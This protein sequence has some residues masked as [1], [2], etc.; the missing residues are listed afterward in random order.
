MSREQRFFERKE[1]EDKAENKG[2]LILKAPEEIMRD[3]SYGF[4]G[5]DRLGSLRKDGR[6][7]LGPRGIFLHNIRALFY[8][9]GGNHAHRKKTV[10]MLTKMARYKTLMLIGNELHDAGYKLV[11]PFSID[12]KHIQ[13]LV[14]DWE[15]RGHLASTMTNKFTILRTF[16]GWMS[17]EHRMGELKARLKD[18]QKAVRKT[19]TETDKTWDGKD[20]DVNYEELKENSPLEFLYLALMKEFGLRMQEA[21]M[22]NP[23]RIENGHIVIEHGAKGGRKRTCPIETDS[24]EDILNIA[25]RMAS[26]LSNDNRLTKKGKSLRAVKSRFYRQ[27]NK[28]G[29]SKKNGIVPHGLRHGYANS[30]YASI[31]DDLSP[32]KGGTYDKHNEKHV[33]AKQIVSRNLGHNRTQVSDAY[34]G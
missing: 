15:E 22:L 5:V 30:L 7:R 12:D 23:T 29:I 2:E 21:I 8:K 27:C 1:A 34:I 19:A 14:T 3:K 20:G 26:L 31:S 33:L 13:Y 18:P 10:S 16:M 17:L 11:T 6:S 25:Q 28:Y 24:Q 9:H 4:W 32:I